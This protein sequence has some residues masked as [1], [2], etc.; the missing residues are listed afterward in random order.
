MNLE[1]I[2]SRLAAITPGKW[3]HTPGVDSPA[4]SV[5]VG[6]YD[7]PHGFVKSL[8]WDDHNGE[9]FQPADAEFI[10]H[11]PEDMA[12]LIEALEVVRNYPVLTKEEMDQM[13][14]ADLVYAEGHI[15]AIEAIKFRLEQVLAATTK[16]SL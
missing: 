4:S 2:K 7:E 5:D 12:K 10:A 8:T 11:A 1:D 15:C 3:K 9:V 13:G 16:S 6:E 14:F